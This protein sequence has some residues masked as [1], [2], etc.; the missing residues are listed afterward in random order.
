MTKF[1]LL[2]IIGS[3]EPF[4]AKAAFMNHLLRMASHMILTQR[5]FRESFSANITTERAFACVDAHMA[6]EGMVVGEAVF[7]D[8]AVE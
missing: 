6:L 5:S 4:A 7:A 8:V 1:M 2:S 3:L